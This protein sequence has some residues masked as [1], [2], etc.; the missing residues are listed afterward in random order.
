[1]KTLCPDEEMFVDYLEGRISN[2]E[3][4]GIEEHLSDCDTCLEEF[5]VAGN[6]ERAE[7]GFQSDP[8]PA[9]VTQA[10]LHVINSQTL[11]PSGLLIERFKRSIKDLYA[12]LS[13]FFNPAIW[14][15][16]GFSQIRGSK[17]VVYKDLI[18][19]KKIFREIEAEIEIEKKGEDRTL[20]RVRLEGDIRNKE[21]VRATLK[22]GDRE[23]SSNLFNRGY[24]V[25]EDV[26]FGHYSITF[27]RNGVIL[28]EYFFKIKETHYGR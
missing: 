25:F 22:K 21:D 26:P 28:G 24:A 23:I 5:I 3:R 12:W 11:T 18:R 7:E 13:I 9:G 4:T 27:S 6:L 8:V 10:A 2:D 17:K 20:I 1:M 14:R 19:L 16:W 15:G